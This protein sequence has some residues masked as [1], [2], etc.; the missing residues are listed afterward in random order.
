MSDTKEKNFKL[1]DFNARL[2]AARRMS[3]TSEYSEFK[4]SVSNFKMPKFPSFL[5]S[6]FSKKVGQNMMKMGMVFQ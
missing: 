3:N 5:K 2:G 6:G 1:R 4:P